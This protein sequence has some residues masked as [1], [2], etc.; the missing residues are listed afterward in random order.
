LLLDVG[1][2]DWGG[3]LL[4]EDLALLLL[5]VADGGFGWGGVGGRV[6]LVLEDLLLLVF[7]G[8]VL[9]CCPH[10]TIDLILSIIYLPKK[11]F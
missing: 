9:F 8:F 11:R 10:L 3:L 6:L 7:L 2:L 1:V 4:G 5:V